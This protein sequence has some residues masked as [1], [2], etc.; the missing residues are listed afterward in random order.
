MATFGELRTR[1]RNDIL[2][3]ADTGFYSDAD[4]LNLLVE[5]S[6]EIAGMGG[7]PTEE[8][9]IS[10]ASGSTV[11]VLPSDLSNVELREVTFNN[12]QL[13]FADTRKIRL[14]Q[15]IGGATRYYHYSPRAEGSLDLAPAAH[16]SGSVVLDYVQDLSGV[17]Y[18]SGDEPWGGV[19]PEWHDTILYMA[20]VKA[21]EKGFEYD[22]AQYWLQR[23]Q[24]R[25][26]PLAIYLG[27]ENVL[28]V[29]VGGAGERG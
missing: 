2:V 20:G 18:T 26:Q 22:K 8:T 15:G 3:E 9:S 14:Y 19:L 17:S 5:S 6:I 24:L 16:V 12:F 1:L 28:N 10:V 4:L 21:F 25:L 11:A 27:N 23:L 13:E 7:F 29:Q